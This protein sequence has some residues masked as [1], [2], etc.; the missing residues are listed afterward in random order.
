M[1]IAHCVLVSL[2]IAWTDECC[3]YLALSARKN[4][5]LFRRAVNGEA[6]DLAFSLCRVGGFGFLHTETD[7]AFGFIGWDH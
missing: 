3:I 5:A 4:V 1:P 2:A 7:L 6:N